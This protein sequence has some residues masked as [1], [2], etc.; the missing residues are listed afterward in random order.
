MLGLAW[1]RKQRS[2]WEIF[3]EIV[4]ELIFCAAYVWWKGVNYFVV[5]KIVE[6]FFSKVS[7]NVFLVLCGLLVGVW[8]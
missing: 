1:Q 3:G 6:C 7:V 4:G 2:V 8:V 5:R